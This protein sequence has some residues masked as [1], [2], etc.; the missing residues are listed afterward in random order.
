MSGVYIS[1]KMIC[2]TFFPHQTCEISRQK[3]FSWILFF[4]FTSLFF[5]CFEMLKNENDLASNYQNDV[6][7]NLLGLLDSKQGGIKVV[8]FIYWQGSRAT[9]TMLYLWSGRRQHFT[10]RVWY[11]PCCPRLKSINVLFVFLLEFIVPLENFSLIWRG[12]HCRW[13]LRILTYDR[14]SWP[15]SRRV[16]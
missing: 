7:Q 5:G 16:L 4:S 3:I 6:A 10:L 13:E 15:F 14:Q 9:L 1:L 11:N 2:L 8:L 12:R